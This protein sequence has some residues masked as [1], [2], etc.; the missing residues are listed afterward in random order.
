VA[1]ELPPGRVAAES[2]GGG[3][4]SLDVSDEHT[5]EIRHRPA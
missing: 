2:T 1:P 4:V 5:V 3:R